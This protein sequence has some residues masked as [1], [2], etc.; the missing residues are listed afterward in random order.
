MVTNGFGKRGRMRI[1]GNARN[2]HNDNGKGLKDKMRDKYHIF[3]RLRK[4]QVK[5]STLQNRKLQKHENH[6]FLMN[7]RLCCREHNE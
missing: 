3:I 1:T 7:C 4:V 6:K 5:I 2:R